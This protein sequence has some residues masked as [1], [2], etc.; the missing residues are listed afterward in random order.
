MKKNDEER[1]GR[2]EERGGWR[3][4]GTMTI[5]ELVRDARFQRKKERERDAEDLDSSVWRV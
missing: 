3:K 4:R 1:G 5:I 2:E